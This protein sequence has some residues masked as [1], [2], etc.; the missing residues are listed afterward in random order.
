MNRIVSHEEW[1]RAR[2]DFLQ[3]E[4]E[5]TRL[6]DELG[7]A[8]RALPWERVTTEY[9]FQGPDG[10]VRLAD[11]FAGR[12]QLLVYHFMFGPDWEKGCKSCSFWADGFTLAPAHLAQRDVSFVAISRAPVERLQAFARRMGWTF[13]WVSSGGNDFNADYAVSFE[14]RDVEERRLA[15]NFGTSRPEGTEMPGLSCFWRDD[16]GTVCHTYSTYGRG[17]D[18]MNPVYQLLD[19]TPRGRDE[20]GLPFP[21][22]WVRLRDEYGV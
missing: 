11:L 7:A 12:R 19:V 10:A 1:L 4:K 17:I 16:D 20:D 3:R 6:R 14:A 18:A 21:M 13:F 22:A 8:R 15:Y 5:L 2:V 9:V